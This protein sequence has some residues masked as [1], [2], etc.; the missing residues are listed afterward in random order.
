[1]SVRRNLENPSLDL[2]LS[3]PR[4]TASLPQLRSQ[5]LEWDRASKSKSSASDWWR[6]CTRF[7]RLLWILDVFGKVGSYA[8]N[9]KICSWNL[10]KFT[11]KIFEWGFQFRNDCRI[12]PETNI[13]P[14]N[15]W[16]EDGF[17]F[18]VAYFQGRSLS[19]RERISSDKNLNNWFSEFPPGSFRKF[20]SC[21]YS[22]ATETNPRT[23][24][25]ADRNEDIWYDKNCKWLLL[26]CTT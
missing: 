1:M 10:T 18:G 21:L 9:S 20:G 5:S 16:L 24:F 6:A 22:T 17:P 23:L 19:F 2:A 7:Q 26:T 13:A 12:L 15:W 25:W 3:K 4:Q 8:F 11:L 14:E